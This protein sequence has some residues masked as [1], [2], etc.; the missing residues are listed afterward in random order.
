MR[1]AIGAAV[2]LDTYS[3]K[4]LKKHI[5]KQHPKKVILRNTSPPS[6]GVSVQD[7]KWRVPLVGI[8]SVGTSPVGIP[9]VGIHP[10]GIPLVGIPPV[11]IPVSEYPLMFKRFMLK[12]V[13]AGTHCE[14]EMN[15]MFSFGA[16]G[17]EIF[18]VAYY[19]NVFALEMHLRVL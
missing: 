19:N 1:G 7:L 10:V 12:N 11:G 5:Q 14:S 17:K 18:A 16:C 4:N 13:L 9:P 15:E 2:H 8:P 6:G 3:I